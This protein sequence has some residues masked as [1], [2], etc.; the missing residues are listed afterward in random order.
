MLLA[1]IAYH[2]TSRWVPND[3]TSFMMSYFAETESK[4]S[5]IRLAFSSTLTFSNPKCVVPGLSA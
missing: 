2:L 3:M 5:A 1:L 4:T